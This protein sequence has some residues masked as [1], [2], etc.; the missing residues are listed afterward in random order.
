M[1]LHFN[2]MTNDSQDTEL[3]AWVLQ[4]ALHDSEGVFATEDGRHIQLAK[5]MQDEKTGRTIGK[6]VFTLFRN[7]E[8]KRLEV[9]DLDIVLDNASASSLRF[10]ERLPQSSD[11]NEYYHV[12]VVGNEQHLLV[13]TVNRY[14]VAGE[15]LDGNF[16]VHASAFPF[17]LTVFESI[18]AFNDWAGLKTEKEIGNTGIRVGGFAKDFSAP[19]NVFRKEGDGC[20][21]FLIGVVDSYED[22]AVRF[23]PRTLEFAIVWLRT[24]L[25]CI[26]VA[27]GREV[28]DLENLAAGKIIA[29]NADIKA[30]F[31]DYSKWKWTSA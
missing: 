31:A 1:P 6:F 23:G 10:L 17:E 28:F 14:T 13:E 2:A 4:S 8:E 25:G 16:D 11:S 29:M 19:G 12:N 27:A 3:L 9:L 26:P 21:S 15:L 24:A 20:F 18:D 22:V 30:D 7:E 5:R